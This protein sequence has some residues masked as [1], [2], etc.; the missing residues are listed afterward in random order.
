MFYLITSHLDEGLAEKFPTIAR[1]LAKEGLKLGVDP[2]PVVP[3]AHYMVGGIRVDEI[4][5]FFVQ[6]KAT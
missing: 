1:R 6:T 5:E 2:I 3:A 4:D